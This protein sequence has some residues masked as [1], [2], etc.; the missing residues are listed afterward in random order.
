MY[1]PDHF[2][3]YELLPKDFYNEHKHSGNLIWVCFDI[4]L[5]R[6]A[7]LIRKRYGKMTAN[8][9]KW[10]GRNHNRGYRHFDCGMGA[11]LSQHK[12][13]R[14]VDLIPDN[15]TA[16]EIRE[17]IK[18]NPNCRDFKRIMCIEDGV[19]WLHIDTRNW[20]KDVYG[21]KVVTH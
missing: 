2:A 17:D 16:E 21:L 11:T 7:D 12:F 20:Y 13:G 1:V 14:A 6:S 4:G 19:D 5:L 3:P 10:G 15:V 18:N 8:D 9:W